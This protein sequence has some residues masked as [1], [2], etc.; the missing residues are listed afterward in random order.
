MK[1][2]FSLLL[3]ALLVIAGCK[4]KQAP[5]PHLEITTLFQ[6]EREPYRA[7]ILNECIVKI[8]DGQLSF[9]SNSGEPLF[10]L[11]DK[12]L[13]VS[14]DLYYKPDGYIIIGKKSGDKTLY[15]YYDLKGNQITGFR[16]E[17]AS[18]F[19]GDY[20]PVKE[21]GKLLIINRKGETVA[22]TDYKLI[23]PF[24][25]GQAIAS[26]ANGYAVINTKGEI[27]KPLPWLGSGTKDDTRYDIHEERIFNNILVVL[28]PG[29]GYGAVDLDGKE[30]IPCVYNFYDI[31]GQGDNSVFIFEKTDKENAE[32]PLTYHCYDINGKRLFGDMEILGVNGAACGKIAI[33]VVDPQDKDLTE[34]WICSVTGEKMHKVYGRNSVTTPFYNGQAFGITT[35]FPGVNAVFY[36]I[37]DTA[38]NVWDTLEYTNLFDYNGYFARV[39]DKEHELQY[40]KV[41]RIVK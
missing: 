26:T 38:G 18:P 27:V 1:T 23:Y 41:Q 40:V 9:F 19:D 34:T 32:Q 39:D 7:V 8:K 3:S 6:D 15:A 17:Y 37:I 11:N 35:S 33:N 14:E 28:V 25:N 29:E 36:G 30:V 21:K 10:E 13:V 24:Q 20:A 12:D 4:E 31:Y 2:I 16:F 5:K 22:T